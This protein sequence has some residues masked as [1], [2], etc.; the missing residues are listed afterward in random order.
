MRRPFKYFSSASSMETLSTPA[1]AEMMACTTGQQSYSKSVISAPKHTPAVVRI[2]DQ[3]LAGALPQGEAHPEQR[4]LAPW[5]LT[6]SDRGRWQQPSCRAHSGTSRPGP[7]GGH[8]PGICS[9]CAFGWCSGRS[10]TTWIPAAHESQPVGGRNVEG[11][12]CCPCTFFLVSC[13]FS[14]WVE[15]F[16]HNI[17]MKMKM[18]NDGMTEMQESATCWIQLSSCTKSGSR[19][20]FCNTQGHLA[21][22]VI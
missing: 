18:K 19:E 4:G 14:H 15:L 10:G 13:I 9:Q 20:C 5:I 11:L 22:C 1:M 8:L 17:K 3:V 21:G 12:E 16:F 7:T 6:R 2:Y